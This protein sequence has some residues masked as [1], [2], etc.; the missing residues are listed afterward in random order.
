MQTIGNY[1]LKT[2][3]AEIIRHVEQGE[4]FLITNRGRTV[5]RLSPVISSHSQQSVKNVIEEMLATKTKTNCSR[6]S[7]QTLRAEGRRF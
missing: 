4:E 3:L 2:K 6:L 1:E 7:T 5:A